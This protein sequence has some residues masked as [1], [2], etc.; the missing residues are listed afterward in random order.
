MELLNKV[1]I[2]RKTYPS[3][4]VNALRRLYNSE[5]F[6]RRLLVIALEQPVDLYTLLLRYKGVTASLSILR[7]ISSI[8][9]LATNKLTIT[10]DRLLQVLVKPHKLITLYNV[11]SLAYIHKFCPDKFQ[12]T[13]I[14]AVKDKTPLYEA[15]PSY[16]NV[17]VYRDLY[18]YSSIL[19]DKGIASILFRSIGSDVERLFEG[20][21]L[22]D[23]ERNIIVDSYNR[24]LSSTIQL[25]RISSKGLHEW[26]ELMERV[27][28]EGYRTKYVERAISWYMDSI[29]RLIEIVFR[30]ILNTAISL[31][32]A[33][34]SDISESTLRSNRVNSSDPSIIRRSGY[35][36]LKLLLESSLYSDY[37]SYIEESNIEYGVILSSYMG[38][39]KEILLKSVKNMGEEYRRLFINEGEPIDTLRRRLAERSDLGEISW[40]L[41][42]SR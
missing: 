18:I 41:E 36:I 24:V 1:L 26:N 2:E 13:I 32:G 27:R 38:R 34:N 15:N 39:L 3:S 19:A 35:S 33:I 23:V 21:R 4:I 25:L 17:I 20:S 42:R 12:F 6:N 40:I 8:I 16:L 28:R 37:S 9:G 14:R 11:L 10:C 22:E 29:S 31:T 7:K 5:E 30:T